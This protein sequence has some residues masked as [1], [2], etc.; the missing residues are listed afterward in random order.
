VTG[1][2]YRGMFMGMQG[3]ILDWPSSLRVP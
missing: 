3:V 1:G 2:Y